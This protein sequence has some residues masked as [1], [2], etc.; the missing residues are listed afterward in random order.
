MKEDNITSGCTASTYCPSNPVTRGDMAIFVMRGGFNQLLPATEP[1]IASIS[2]NTFAH[3][4]TATFTVT[5]TN[6]NFAQGV[7][8]VTPPATS[9]V[10]LN[11][12]TVTSPTSMQVSLTASVGA[13]LQP[14]SIYVQT[15]KEEAVLPNGLTI[16]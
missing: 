16:Q 6:T 3:E 13:L 11:S 14:M 9:G 4:T 1:V 8:T 5:G 15:G 2:P 10:T 7:T 12:V